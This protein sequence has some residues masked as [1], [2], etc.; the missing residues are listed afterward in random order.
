MESQFLLHLDLNTINVFG[1]QPCG[2]PDAGDHLG[3]CILF[4]GLGSVVLFMFG[5]VRF[6]FEGREFLARE[7][8][9]AR[10]QAFWD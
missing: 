6:V 5:V 7:R 10:T 8:Q 3:R 4:I 1:L 2:W 9:Y